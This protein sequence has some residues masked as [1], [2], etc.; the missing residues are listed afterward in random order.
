MLP[1]LNLVAGHL[2]LR[3]GTLQRSGPRSTSIA[4]FTSLI[5]SHWPFTPII[6]G[7]HA[8]SFGVRKDGSAWR[9]IKPATAWGVEPVSGWVSTGGQSSKPANEHHP[10]LIVAVACVE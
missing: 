3:F 8:M 4:L 7:C 6:S 5:S 2:T 10:T 1:R 9:W